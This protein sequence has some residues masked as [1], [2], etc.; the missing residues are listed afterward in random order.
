V[1]LG[2]KNSVSIDARNKAACAGLRKR[3]GQYRIRAACSKAFSSRRRRGSSVGNDVT[4]LA[5]DIG[6]ANAPHVHRSKGQLRKR[7]HAWTCQA[8]TIHNALLTKKPTP[9]PVET[10]VANTRPVLCPPW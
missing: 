5:I 7:A 1:E 10:R 4:A 2:Q 9:T 3:T 8:Q 6:L